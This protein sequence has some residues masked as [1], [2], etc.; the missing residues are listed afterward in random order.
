MAAVLAIHRMG[1]ELVHKR[2]DYNAGCH[3]LLDYVSMLLFS[4]LELVA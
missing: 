1:L 3:L 2:E 4:F